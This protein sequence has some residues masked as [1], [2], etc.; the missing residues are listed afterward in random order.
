MAVSRSGRELSEIAGGVTAPRGWRAGVAACGIKRVGRDD[1]AVL[2]SSLDCDAGGVFTANRV[3]AAPVVLD[4]ARVPGSRIRALV[5]N[6]GNANACTGER[7][8]ADAVHMAELAATRLGLEP[9]QVL[10][11]STGVI[12]R[13]L[14]MALI[15]P[16]IATACAHLGDAGDAAAEAIMTTDTRSKS[17]AV[18]LEIGDVAIRVGGMA[19]GS[20]MIHPDLAT[21]LAF[22]TTDARV[23]PGLAHS[24]AARV[25]DRS[26]NLLTV[27]GDSSTNDTFLVL[28]GGGAGGPEI[29][30]GS[31]EA[32]LL[33]GAVLEVAR[34]L[35]RAIAA[36]G[37]GATRLITVRVAGAASEAHARLAARAVASSSLVKAA[38]HGGDPNWGRIVCALG[39]SGAELAL[40][41]LAVSIGGVLVFSRGVPVDPDLGRVRAAFERP[42]VEIEAELALGDG[43]AEAWG[44]DLSEEYVRINAEYTT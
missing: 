40:D 5:V 39:Y 17:A 10:V 44:C 9:G 22:V 8:M 37:E 31:S 19:K 13:R 14:P 3:Q 7:G 42:E 35:A 27:D 41:S 23:A 21:M 16:G 26:F 4:R 30:A 2:V 25:A 24:L 18:E 28:A 20:G 29:V 32:E 33:E 12:G 36:D 43:A 38:V 6:S 15:E 1:L 34:R 11:C